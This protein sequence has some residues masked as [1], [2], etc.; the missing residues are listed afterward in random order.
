MGYGNNSRP[1]P[2]P[3]GMQLSA[4]YRVEALVRLS[5][6]RMFYLL[7]DDRPDQVRRRCWDCGK[8]SSRRSTNCEHC[9]HLFPPIQRFLM[10]VRWNRKAYDPYLAFY[11]KK[12]R[13]PGL[14]GADDVFLHEGLLCS[15]VRYQNETLMLDEGAPLSVERV[16]G[17][18]QRCAG[19]LAFLHA[20]G[21]GLEVLSEAN[22]VYRREEDT[23]L[24][25][26]PNVA[27]AAEG[28]MPDHLRGEE[29]RYL[30][31]MLKRFS[32]VN[33]RAVRDFMESVEKGAYDSPLGFGQ[34]VMERFDAF[35]RTPPPR[36]VAGMSDV[37]LA[38]V[39]NE[40]CW[41]WVE[42]GQGAHLY[43]VADG[44]GGHEAGEVASAVATETLCRVASELY[45]RRRP[46]DHEGL[47]RLLGEA[48]RVA[49]NAVKDLAEARRND[50]GTTLVTA[51]VARDQAVFAN[52]GD[53]RAY[54]L[55][56]RRLR[57]VTRDHSLVAKMVEQRRITAEE[58]RH[59]P[60]SNILLRTVGT[61]RDVEVDTFREVLEPGDQLLLCSDGLWGEVDDPE[62][63]TI[64]RRFND[65]RACARELIRAAHHGGGRDNVTVVLV[66]HDGAGSRAISTAPR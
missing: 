58:A 13:H 30:G 39:L 31:A 25:F 50:M 11:E 3:P 64:V 21:V 52:V 19:L 41:A 44:M 34:A 62:L 16:L 55:R 36:G 6:G 51:L 27:L 63:A 8:A 2:F 1:P 28:R 17:L 4:W 65:P 5:E 7:T 20:N 53:S 56:D 24:L 48:V 35:P 26:D 10:S 38:R 37:G 14:L 66:G 46:P 59:H 47:E 45:E 42:L 18:A 32:P 40:D 54:L 29:L 60:N 22:F 43:V 9:G 61:E 49:N 57:Q 12:L 33:G 15:I 23:F